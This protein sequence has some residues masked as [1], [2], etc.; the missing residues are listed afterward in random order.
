MSI[1]STFFILESYVI[2]G[3]LILHGCLDS[4]GQEAEES[5]SPQ[6]HGEPAKHLLAELYPLRG[7]GRRGQG[8]GAITGKVLGS[9]STG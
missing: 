3:R 1:K 2:I 6:K 4:I 5:A 9:L 8:I 7:S